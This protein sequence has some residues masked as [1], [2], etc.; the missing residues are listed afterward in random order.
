MKIVKYKKEKSG[1]Y[2]I[3]LEDGSTL[4]TYEDVIIN[5]KLL[6]HNKIDSELKEKLEIE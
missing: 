6:Y 4:D 1:K 5:N 2:K 3:Y